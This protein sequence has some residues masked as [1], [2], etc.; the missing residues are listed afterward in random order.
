VDDDEDLKLAEDL[1]AIL[2]TIAEEDSALVAACLRTLKLGRSLTVTNRRKLKEVWKRH[3]GGDS[4]DDV[5]ESD[6]V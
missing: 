1:E 3:L 6:F 2:E 4:D 5:D